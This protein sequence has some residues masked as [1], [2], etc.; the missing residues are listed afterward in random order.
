LEKGKEGEALDEET[1]RKKGAN[2]NETAGDVQADAA[3]NC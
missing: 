2:E 3:V 1:V